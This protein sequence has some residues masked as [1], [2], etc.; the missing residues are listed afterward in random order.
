MQMSRYVEDPDCKPSTL[1]WY[2]RLE[3][4][5]SCVYL[6]G[7]MSSK[8]RTPGGA[9]VNAARSFPKLPSSGGCT[10]KP[11]R[12]SLIRDSFA[13]V[14]GTT[15]DVILDFTEGLDADVCGIRLR[16]GSKLKPSTHKASGG[17][18]D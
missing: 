16:E 10:V 11:Q 7:W 6:S 13:V 18:L 3:Y 1:R 8:I 2:N 4:L 5:G 17:A 12:E 15:R 9:R 14:S